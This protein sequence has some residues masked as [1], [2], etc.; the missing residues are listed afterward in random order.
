MLVSENQQ[1][2]QSGQFREPPPSKPVPDPPPAG[3]RVPP[4][5]ELL[6]FDVTNVERLR[7]EKGDI[8][9][10]HSSRTLGMD[11]AYNL[12]SV[13]RVRAGLAPEVPI[14]ILPP[15]ISK[16]QVLTAEGFET[17]RENRERHEEE[18]KTSE[19]GG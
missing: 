4:G 19:A 9:L 8:I 1:G 18:E 15:E 7:P 6:L 14:I 16:V 11:E 13:F 12:W 17:L 10:L 5:I 3:E 2:G